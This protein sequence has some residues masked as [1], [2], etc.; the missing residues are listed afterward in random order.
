VEQTTFQARLKFWLL[1]EGR[2]SAEYLD[3]LQRLMAAI[4]RMEHTR[5]LEDT[6]RAIR[7]LGRAVAQSPFKQTIDRAVMQW[8]RYRL[9]RKMPGLPLPTLDEL[10]RGTD[11]L[12]TNMDQWKAKAVAEG[13][14]IGEQRGLQMGKLEGKLEGKKGEARGEA[15]R[16]VS[17]PATPACPTVWLNPAGHAR[18]DRGGQPRT[19][20]NLVRR[21]DQRATSCRRVHPDVQLTRGLQEMLSPSG[22]PHQEVPSGLKILLPNSRILHNP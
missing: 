16:R 15:R 2:F 1:D 10:L 14:L 17:G 22:R 6:K 4:F 19:D 5:D 9:S 12:E 11:M 13:V 3:G 18:A 21:R 7:Y 8:M 20:R